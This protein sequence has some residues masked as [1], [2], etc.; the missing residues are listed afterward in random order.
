MTGFWLLI[1]LNKMAEDRQ[2]PEN[3]LE[4]TL[5]LANAPN[6][7]DRQAEDAIYNQIER[8]SSEDYFPWFFQIIDPDNCFS[9]T[10]LLENSAKSRLSRAIQRYCDSKK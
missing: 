3:A 5:R 8:A 1:F 6:M 9:E 7:T 10:K 2:T 4:F